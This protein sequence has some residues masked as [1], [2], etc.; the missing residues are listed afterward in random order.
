MIKP[1]LILGHIEPGEYF[2]F[3]GSRT[4]YKA[5]TRRPMNTCPY[6]GTMWVMNMKTFKV[7]WRRCAEN[8]SRGTS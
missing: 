5:I 6:I 1:K 4:R 3:P 8:V 2:T 7:E